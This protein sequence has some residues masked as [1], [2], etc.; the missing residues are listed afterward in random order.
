MPGGASIL[1]P[2][3]QTL[4]AGALRG[5][6]AEVL[7]APAH[8]YTRALI[9]AAPG[10]FWDFHNFRELPKVTHAQPA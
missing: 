5:P 8:A 6:A 2:R 9:D 4:R 7:A 10:R 1:R 3:S